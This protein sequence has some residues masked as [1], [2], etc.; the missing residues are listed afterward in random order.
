MRRHATPP[1][2]LISLA[3]A[4]GGCLTRRQ[5][6]AAGLSAEQTRGLARGWVTLA[7]GVY[8]IKEPTWRSRVW[9]GVLC[10][11]GDAVIGGAAALYL[12]GALSD[13]P[14]SIL[15]WRTHT[16]RRAH[17]P[18]V[19]FRE[20]SRPAHG[21]PVRT[22]PEDSILDLA[23]GASQG[24]GHRRP[25]TGHAVEGDD[26]R[27]ASRGNGPQGKGESSTAHHRVVH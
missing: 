4:Q 18:G 1:A 13:E 14:A 9:A 27:A 11:R 3:N 17:C 2:R 8:C 12:D 26:P 15:I 10:C 6:L 19:V 24:G 22:Y 5:C 21:H 23:R 25:G 7:R 16:A 20:G